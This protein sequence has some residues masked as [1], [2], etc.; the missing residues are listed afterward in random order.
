M[1]LKPV[2]TVTL[3]KTYYNRGFFNVGVA[4][5]KHITD[6]D[7]PM[8]LY[9]GEKQEFVQGRVS[10]S[11]NPNR[12]PRI[13]GGHKLRKWFQENYQVMDRLTVRIESPFT[14]WII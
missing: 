6:K 7:G 12:T 1:A 3:H 2:A 8:N 10:R 13:Y 5:Q 9:L 14:I 4:F 11:A